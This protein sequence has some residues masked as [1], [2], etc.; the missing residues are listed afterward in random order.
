MTSVAATAAG[1]PNVVRNLLY[2]AMALFLVTIAIGIVNGLDLYEFDHDQ[3]LTHVHSGTLGWI[4]LSIVAASAWFARGIDR[5]LAWSLAILVPIYV[6]AFYRAI[7]GLRAGVGGLL[8]IA[9]LWLV[10]WAWQMAWSVRS[11]P[12]IA[13]ALGLT[14]FTYGAIIGVLRQVQLAGGP[15]PFPGSADIVGAHAAAMVFSYLILVAMGLIEWRVKRTAGRPTS[16]LVQVGLLF[17]GGLI[18]SLTLLF[19]PADAV[20]AAGGIYL[21][22]ELIAVVMF[23]VRVLPASVRIDWMG[24]GS[25]RHIAA[26]SIFV[27]VATAIFLYVIFRFIQDPG[28]ANNPDS[29]AGVLTASDHAA[30]IGVVTNLVLGLGLGLAADRHEGGSGSEQLAFWLMNVGLAIFLVGLIAESAMIKRVGSPMMGV[31]ILIALAIVALRLRAS[32]LSATET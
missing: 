15:S 16:G 10:A 23:A 9:I 29:I 8:L 30:F 3:L 22:V 31:G 5:R 13:I 26:S 21:L 6:A 32:D 12:A 27:V 28:I 24:A 14:T 19:L 11:V 7:P 25:A 4:T 17:A 2:V 18:I 1:W 20:Q